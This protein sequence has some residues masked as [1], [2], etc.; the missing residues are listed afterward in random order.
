MPNGILHIY[1]RDTLVHVYL[2][3]LGNDNDNCDSELVRYHSL[4]RIIFQR[5]NLQLCSLEIKGILTEHQIIFFGLLWNMNW[6]IFIY[7]LATRI[8]SVNCDWPYGINCELWM[9]MLNSWWCLGAS[10]IWWSETCNSRKLKY[11]FDG[12]CHWLCFDPSD[13]WWYGYKL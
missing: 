2:C 11:I 6:L 10:M 5:Y 8:I 9:A 13:I 3:I 4:Y 7:E 12:G 1:A